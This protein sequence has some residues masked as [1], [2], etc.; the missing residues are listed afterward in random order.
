MFIT[1]G[2]APVAVNLKGKEHSAQGEEQFL[3]PSIPLSSACPTVSTTAALQEP[4]GV[5]GVTG[6]VDRASL[7]KT[8]HGTRGQT[9]FSLILIPSTLAHSLDCSRY[10]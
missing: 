8:T 2:F 1:K 9:E 3:T 6:E 7:Q 5:G 10:S 4:F